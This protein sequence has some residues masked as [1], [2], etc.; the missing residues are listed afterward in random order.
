[1]IF[2]RE[3]QFENFYSNNQAF[4][5]NNLDTGHTFFSAKFKG[6]SNFHSQTQRGL[7]PAGGMTARSPKRKRRYSCTQPVSSNASERLKKNYIFKCRCCE[8]LMR[9]ARKDRGIVTLANTSG[10]GGETTHGFG[11]DN[12]R[13]SK[14]NRGT[15]EENGESVFSS[16]LTTITNSI[17]SPRDNLK[18]FLL[19]KKTTGT[20][21]EF[22]VPVSSVVDPNSFFSDSDPQIF[23]SDTDSAS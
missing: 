10:G 8:A 1:V 15:T 7:V 5:L 22:A 19:K 3:N 14:E 17:C 4:F 6:R 20:V 18:P 21:L 2:D 16:L 11:K 13:E 23:F 9:E 12:G